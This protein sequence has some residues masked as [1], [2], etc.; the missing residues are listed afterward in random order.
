MKKLL[1][2]VGSIASVLLLEGCVNDP[3]CGICDPDNLYLQNIT[4]LNYASKKIH[5]LSPECEGD[6]CPEPFDEGLVFI[7]KIGLCQDTE[8]AQESSRPDDYCKIS[9]GIIWDG[10]AFMF[11]NL[12]DPR[13]IELVRKSP[14]DPTFF[15]VYDWKTKV[16]FLKGP[17]TR[18]HAAYVEGDGNDPG[19]VI[20][21]QSKACIDNLADQGIVYDGDVLSGDPDICEDVFTDGDRIVPLKTR[22]EG[23]FDSYRGETDWRA[24][25]CDSPD[26]GPDTCCNV[27]DYETSVNVW[28]YGED[29]NGNR[30]GPGEAV[31]FACDAQTGN[32]FTECRHFIPHVDRSGETQDF[33]YDWDQDGQPEKHKLA[34]L[35]KFRETHPDE[36]PEGFEHATVECETDQD[37]SDAHLPGT[38]CIGTN[39]EGACYP[40]LGCSD[41]R[42]QA[43]WYVDCRADAETTGKIGFCVDTRYR[44]VG[45]GACYTAEMDTQRCDVLDPDDCE[46]IPAGSR[47]AHCDNNDDRILSSDECCQ[48]SAG[49][50]DPY[51][52]DYVQPIDRYD[53]HPDLPEHNFCYCGDPDK[54]PDFCTDLI[55]EMCTEPFGSLERHDG[56]SNAGR[57][58]TRFVVG[59]GGVIYDPA[60]KGLEWRFNWRIDPGRALVE[61]CAGGSFNYQ[62]YY[63]GSLA[64]CSGFE[65]AVHFETDEDGE[66]VRDKVGNTLEGRDEYRFE[67][68]QFHVVPGS[69]FP[70]DNLR[71]GACDQF[72]IRF[73]NRFDVTPSNLKKLELWEIEEVG[74]DD[75]RNP[76]CWALTHK[77]AGGLDCVDSREDYTAGGGDL[78]PCLRVDILDF[79]R[80]T[81][82]VDVDPVEYSRV[83]FEKGQND[84]FGRQS[85]GRYR[86]VVPGMA[87]YESLEDLAEDHATDSQ[88]FLDT[89]QA[90]FHDVCGMPLI[91]AG[92]EGP[93]DY[94]YDF[95]ID[96]PKCREDEDNDTVQV[97][98]D[99]A[100][101][102]YNPDQADADEDGFGDVSDT[103]AVTFDEFSTGDSDT[104]GVGNRC[105]RCRQKEDMVN[106]DAEDLGV[107]PYMWV[108]NSPYQGDFDRDG[109]GDACDN[110]VTVA[111]CEDYGPE[112]EGLEPHEVGEPV[113]DDDDNV[114]Q[115]DYDLD[116]IGDECQENGVGI[117]QPGAA[118]VIGFTDDE[119]FDQDGIVNLDDICPRQPT[120]ADPCTT[121]DDCATNSVCMAGD[122]ANQ[123]VCNHRDSDGDGVG[124]VCDTC[125]FSPNA[126]QIMD[127]GMQE[128]DEDN[129][130]VG[131]MCE[132]SPQCY[133][134]KDPR[135]YSFYEVSVENFCCTT[136]YPGDGEY[137]ENPDG[138]WGCEGLCDPDGLPIKLECDDEPESGEERIPDGS[139]CRTLPGAVA[140]LP[141]ML[142]LP[143]GCQEALDDAGL[144]GETNPRY[145][146]VDF[147]GDHIEMWDHMCFLPQWDQDFDGIGDACDLCGFAFDPNNE[148]YVAPNGKVWKMHGKYCSGD[149]DIEVLCSGEDEEGT[150][151][152]GETDTGDETGEETGTEETG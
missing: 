152:T 133:L 135:P 145:T 46:T 64:M 16:L 1:I 10:V 148:P 38:Q 79:W 140:N 116:L 100:P 49:T 118:A 22:L 55:E 27:C 139:M 11:N 150:G 31:D 70:T 44:N 90:A 3:D 81:I 103:C 76:D 136:L 94:I 43:A 50:C 15:E 6:A 71:I 36:R 95:S 19:V 18:Y 121:D 115:S 127:G 102:Y 33:W 13:S 125:P 42:C 101:D 61:Q 2:S 66:H 126:S 123:A 57:Y 86:L 24:N 107:L 149:Y 65:Y 132:T 12:L 9:P 143:P 93:A 4:G 72:E 97:S 141:G 20:K 25:S 113:A 109:I 128:D 110:C 45:T 8:E 85:T 17:I 151:D 35:D 129:D 98:C 92:H 117:Q 124:N 88:E 62:D 134:R 144:T 67:T 29:E 48:G 34:F 78:A 99:N 130:F 138:S 89:Y 146:I 28:K 105:D 82:R 54:Q 32:P 7:E 68:P 51:F 5:V 112:S 122:G 83:L 131:Q 96:P 114:C 91:T 60:V 40:G 137:V 120:S 23:R 80:G 14:S 26:E 47:L 106:M 77:V 58:I 52:Q 56:V 30:V 73:S 74:C 63:A 142:E 147:D 119:D 108:R 41:T 111:N 53:R 37:C 87:H 84:I 104:D 39:S 59:S 69:G 75:L 21:L